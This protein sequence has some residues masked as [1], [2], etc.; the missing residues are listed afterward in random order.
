MQ[1]E[2][3]A[4]RRMLQQRSIPDDDLRRADK[5]KVRCRQ[6]R[7]VQRLANMAGGIG[8]I[9]MFMEKRAAR[10]KVEE[11]GESQQRQCAARNRSTENGYSPVHKRHFS[12]AP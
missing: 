6:R 2:G 9:R 11:G 5:V 10:G 1:R 3:I 8:P 7:H 12:L 4:W